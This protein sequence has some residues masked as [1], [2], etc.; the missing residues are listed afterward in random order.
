[1]GEVELLTN[2][3]NE[4]WISF[5]V[6]SFALFFLAIAVLKGLQFLAT[7]FGWESKKE[8]RLKKLEKIQNDLI[9]ENNKLKTEIS[10]AEKRCK[11]AITETE[12]R[13]D[14]RENIHWEES[15]VIKGNYD[16]RMI[17]LDD[18]LDKII[19][20]LDKKDSLDFK[21]LRHSIVQAGESYIE[22]GYVTIRQLK[23][24]E[25]MFEEYTTNYNG[26]SYVSTLMTKVRML[27]VIGKL[28]EHG[29]D[30]ED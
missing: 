30:I 12:K 19:E 10:E 17:N 18:K 5:F 11:D 1:M 16:N 27:P 28:N 24:L 14:D 13:F 29:E 21:K 23:A 2:A 20:K 26:N 3:T 22:K 15:K 25:D 7:Y 9:A 6:M 4:N 8:R